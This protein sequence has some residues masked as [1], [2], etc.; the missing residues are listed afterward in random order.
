LRRG[1]GA[2]RPGA[3]SKGLTSLRLLYKGAAFAAS[4]KL[5]IMRLTLTLCLLCITAGLRS[6]RN[7]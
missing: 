7:A 3:R 4:L 5:R 1:V 6:E 2:T